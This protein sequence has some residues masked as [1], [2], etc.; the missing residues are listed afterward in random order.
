V[1]CLAALETLYQL[2][3]IINKGVGYP[4]A[5]L[6]EPR[7]SG[8]GWRLYTDHERFPERTEG[9]RHDQMSHG[10]ETAQLSQRQGTH[11]ASSGKLQY[12]LRQLVVGGMLSIPH[13]APTTHRFQNATGTG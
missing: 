5:E 2:K 8:T 11:S 13:T 12:T 10:D 7:L 3:G 4:Q 6:L 9:N 1:I